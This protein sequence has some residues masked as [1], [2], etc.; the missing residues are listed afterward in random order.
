MQEVDTV[1]IVIAAYN[2]EQFLRR[3]VLSAL[4]QT[5][6]VLEIIVVDDASRDQTSATVE[7]LAE[8]FQNVVLI[9]LATNGGPSAARNAGFAAARGSW[10]AVLDADDAITE[11]RIE[12]MIEAARTC[13][14]DIVL[15]AFRFYYL[16]TDTLGPN[17]LGFESSQPESVSVTQFVSK[18]R[19]LGTEA[20]WGLL[21]PMFRRSFLEK[22]TLSYPPKSR[23]GEDFLLMVDALLAGARLVLCRRPGYLYTHRTSGLSRTTLNYALMWQHTEQLAREARVMA[24]PGLQSALLGRAEALKRF[25]ASNQ[26]A[27]LWRERRLMSIG[28]YALADSHARVVLL[29]RVRLKVCKALGCVPGCGHNAST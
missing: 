24:I 13:N 11:D 22:H 7:R 15:D 16:E 4:R 28:L 21:Q 5:Y 6:R 29:D 1:S 8:E 19:P 10:I 23:H 17:A 27:R 14:A 2:A 25:S 12:F 18:A 9:R 3:A 20:D 26:L